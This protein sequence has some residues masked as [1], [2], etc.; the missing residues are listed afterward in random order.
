M[1]RGEIWWVD[2]GIPFGSEPGFKRPVLIIQDDSFNRS[3]INTIV[4]IAVTSNLNLS[5]APGNVLI[6]KKDSNLS[7]DS[8]V[9]VSQIVTLDKERFLNK[10]GK[11][12]TNKLNEVGEGL[13]LVT[14]LE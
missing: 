8:V 13:R 6:T 12:K 7:K 10:A 9:D 3:N 14:G 4:S 1:T 2:L 5:E 11:L